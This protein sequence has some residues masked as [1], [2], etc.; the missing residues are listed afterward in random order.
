VVLESK[1]Y[2]HQYWAFAT[3]IYLGYKNTWTRLICLWRVWRV[4]RLSLNGAEIGPKIPHLLPH[5]VFI[6]DTYEVW[7]LNNETALTGSSSLNFIWNWSGPLQR[8]FILQL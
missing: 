6:Q 3:R 4:A 5:H 1:R 2:H 7:I 8:S